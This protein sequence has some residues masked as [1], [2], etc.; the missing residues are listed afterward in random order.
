[1]TKTVG[2]IW[3]LPAF[4]GIA[5]AAALTAMSGY[6]LG[7]WSPSFLIRVHGLSLTEA[8]LLL[9]VVGSLGGLIGAIWGGALCDRL[10]R[11]DPRWQLRLPAVGAIVSAVLQALFILWPEQHA[12]HFGEFRVPVAMVFMLFGAIF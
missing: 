12:I 5:F 6:G 9:G 7:A 1:F 8:G 3:R 10:V 11:N 4:T 2:A